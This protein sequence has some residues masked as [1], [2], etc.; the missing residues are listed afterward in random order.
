MD[1]HLL[2]AKPLFEL[3]LAYCSLDP[4]KWVAMYFE[5]KYNNVY[6]ANIYKNI[7]HK[8]LPFCL[9]L[10]ELTP[11]LI[12]GIQPSHTKWQNSVFIVLY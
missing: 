10:N 6:V 12:Y 1:C 4:P 3:V 8:W 5:S 2:S 7:I 9:G 11:K